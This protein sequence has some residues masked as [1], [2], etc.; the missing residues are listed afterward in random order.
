M[1]VVRVVA[2]IVVAVVRMGMRISVGIVGVIVMPVVVVTMGLGGHR[3]A[4]GIVPAE[5]ELPRG[6]YPA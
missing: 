4:M 5:T 6:T 2:V 3:E 1:A